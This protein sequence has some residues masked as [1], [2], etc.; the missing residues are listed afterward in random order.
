ML[1]W[2]QRW[3]KRTLK[4]LLDSRFV[5]ASL[6]DVIRSSFPTAAMRSE[7]LSIMTCLRPDGVGP[8]SFGSRVVNFGRVVADSTSEDVPSGAVLDLEKIGWLFKT[9]S[10]SSSSAK[11]GVMLAHTAK[12]RRAL[13]Q[14][15]YSRRELIFSRPTDAFDHFRL[16]VLCR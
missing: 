15:R 14:C 2:C 1:I 8:S 9:A 4:V 5:L 6:K 13:T 16:R 3:V 7:S 11:I 12:V 10:Q